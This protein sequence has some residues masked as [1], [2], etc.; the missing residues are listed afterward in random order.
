[1]NKLFIIIGI[2]SAV[3]FSVIAAGVVTSSIWVTRLDL[4][5]I[6]AIQSN[7]TYKG[8]SIISIATEIGGT[9]AAV[10]LTLIIVIILFLKKMYFAGFWFGM[11]IVTGP[12]ALVSILKIFISRERPEFLRLAEETTKSFPSGHSTASTVLYGLIGLAL[13]LLIRK[14]YLKYLVG[15][16]T[17]LVILFVMSSRIY[18]GVHYP[19]DVLGGLTLGITW[20]MISIT[21][22]TY[23]RPGFLKWLIQK[24]IHDK[25]PILYE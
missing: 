19:T 22:Y 23:I 6:E 1:M 18:L 17:V 14:R 20:I 8:A 2:I 15:F 11:T 13:I 16:M 21:I 12:G 3:L 5:I 7:V 9:E 4:T 10:I 25:S 24:D